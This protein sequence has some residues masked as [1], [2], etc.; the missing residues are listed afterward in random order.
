MRSTH[1]TLVKGCRFLKLGNQ[2]REKLLWWK[3][4]QL[5]IHFLVS[6]NI[7][8]GSAPP[9]YVSS[10]STDS[11]PV[12]SRFTYNGQVSDRSRTG[13]GPTKVFEHV[14]NHRTGPSVRRTGPLVRGPVRRACPTDVNRETDSPR[15]VR[16][17]WTGHYV[18]D[19]S[20]ARIDRG[21]KTSLP[22]LF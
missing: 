9:L 13:P 10:A 16:L 21:V 12:R 1:L 15:T 22:H 20:S 17:M 5:M 14:Q 6:Y 18:A 4:S 2:L 3:K 19:D 8:V 7:P 11:G